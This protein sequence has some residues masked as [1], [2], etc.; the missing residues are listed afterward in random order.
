MS[1]IHAIGAAA[2]SALAFGLSSATPSPSNVPAPAFAAPAELLV[3]ARPTSSEDLGA[4]HEARDALRLAVLDA[5]RA[6]RAAP[7]NARERANYLEAV[8]AYVSTRSEGLSGEGRARWT[9]PLD[10]D[11]EA[12][13]RRQELDGYVSN[14]EMAEAVAA[15]SPE[16]SL[17]L[18]MAKLHN[19]AVGEHAIARCRPPAPL[20]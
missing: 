15:A 8:A 10:R 3:V 16:G 11:V 12:A 2:A 14:A 9:T 13:M 5:A 19:Q 6:F 7:C 18:L 1:W 17:V 20:I 4:G